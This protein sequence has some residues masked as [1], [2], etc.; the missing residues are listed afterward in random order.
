M[1]EI[2]GNMSMDEFARLC[3]RLVAEMGFKIRHSVYREN[4]VVMDAY[5][6]VVGET[7]H[8]VI[9]FLRKDLVKK[10]EIL[11]MVDLE[12]VQVKWMIVT[13]GEF[14]ENAKE[15]QKRDDVTLMDWKDFER[16]LTEFGF[17]EELTRADREKAAREGRFLPSAGE[18]DSL[19]QWAEEFFKAGN[20]NKALDY[21]NQA[22]SIKK[23][24]SAL[25][26]KS[27]ILYSM[28]RY[29]EAL[30]LITSVLEENI[31][32]DSAWFLMGQILEEMGREDEAEEAYAQCVRFNPRS[33]G[34]WIN[35]GNIMV[36]KEKF[37]EALLCYENALRIRQNLP[38]VWNN[39]GVVLKYLKKY[40]EALR[41][42]NAAIQYDPK[43]A[44]AYLNKALLYYDL[45]RYEEATNAVK[46]YLNLTKDPRGYLLLAKIYMKRQMMHDAEINA[47]KVLELDPASIEARD[48]L[49]RITGGKIGDMKG[50]IK[51]AIDELMNIMPGKRMQ[52]IR[53]ML[54][55][56]K[57]LAE[58]GE[59][60]RAKDILEEAKEKIKEHVD[61][62]KLRSVLVHDILE[63]CKKLERTPPENIENMGVEELQN[64]RDTL[65][66]EL[67]ESKVKEIEQKTKEEI[68][69][70]INKLREELREKGYLSPEIERKISSAEEDVH[71]GN[72]KEAISKLTA[73]REDIKTIKEET[74]RRFFV[75]DTIEL[76]EEA[77]IEIPEDIDN[78]D[79]DELKRLR[80]EAIKKLKSLSELE[81]QTTQ[82][83]DMGAEPEEK[84]KEI[85]GLKDL[86]S[87]L[88]GENQKSEK[89]VSGIK[90]DLIMDITEL[91]ELANY[92][93]PERLEN[94]SVEE[95]RELRKEII[96]SLKRGRNI[97]KPEFKGVSHIL[98][99]EGRWDEI[100]TMLNEQEDE[101]ITNSAGMVFYEKGEYEKA[102][103]LFKR[104]LAINPYFKEAEYNLAMCLKALGK[105]DEAK[106]HIKKL[107]IK[108]D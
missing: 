56:A 101:F 41:S 77:E 92:T 96:D 76:L 82:A 80:E 30:S 104:A 31:S 91:A 55:Q 62:E 108:I 54:E 35:R 61:E 42:Y 75:E 57:M 34:C 63:L 73:V 8:Y 16:L 20:M 103:K 25:K 105:D 69:S 107:G 12:R 17:K 97:E 48:I 66:R 58:K 74:V 5:M 64:L 27:K 65:L 90:E 44:D 72:F 36:S 19:L 38:A 71:S 29:D 106:L 87:A 81:S 50:E 100:L 51:R 86:I 7:L 4:I 59:I 102:E 9:I 28:K 84:E 95:L 67:E 3:N 94:L 52:D 99:E 11:D 89:S 43:F 68:V 14:D 33:V 1:K 23:T 2:I 18:V 45:K 85:G 40:D 83:E 88:G 37:E 15:L 10:E 13:T 78:M 21:V 22:L 26:I 32:D 6:P 39:R 47:R 53:D 98:Y 60:E 24:A 46:E 93:I 70:E 49:K 79:I